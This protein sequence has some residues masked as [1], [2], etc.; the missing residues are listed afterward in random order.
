[1]KPVC[2]KHAEALTGPGGPLDHHPAA[3]INNTSEDRNKQTPSSL[4]LSS[5]KITAIKKLLANMF[6]DWLTVEKK[7]RQNLVKNPEWWDGLFLEAC[8]VQIL[9]VPPQE[10]VLTRRNIFP[11]NR[12]WSAE[13]DLGTASTTTSK[14]FKKNVCIFLILP[15]AALDKTQTLPSCRTT[16]SAWHQ[17]GH[18]EERRVGPP[19]LWLSN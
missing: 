15:S 18:K 7:K 11:P 1:M 16:L 9:S 14:H 13:E 10:M 17:E 4:S 2:C 5:K 6:G 12:D 19:P 3:F 8:W